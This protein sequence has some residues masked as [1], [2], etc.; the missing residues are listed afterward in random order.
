MQDE[1]GKRKK[2][3]MQCKVKEEK[4]NKQSEKSRNLKVKFYL[5]TAVGHCLGSNRNPH[6]SQKATGQ[7]PCRGSKQIH[8][9]V[10]N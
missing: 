5:Q 6:M 2:Q 4:R 7:S 8:E 10:Q 3:G 1:R 9:Y